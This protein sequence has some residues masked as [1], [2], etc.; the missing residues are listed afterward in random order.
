MN[1]GFGDMFYNMNDPQV[2]KTNVPVKQDSSLHT[3]II[4]TTLFM[5]GGIVIGAIGFGSFLVNYAVGLVIGL[6]YLFYLVAVIC[7]SDI[8]GYITNLKKFD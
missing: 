7:F 3:M 6:P 1:G 8:R 2:A 4:I 5:I